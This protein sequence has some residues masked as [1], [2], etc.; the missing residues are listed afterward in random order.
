[1]DLRQMQYF[2]AIAEALSFS[3]AANTLFISQSYLSK[4]M[5]E[6][7]Q[8]LGVKLLTRTTRSVTLTEEGETLLWGVRDILKHRDS[9]IDSV[10]KAGTGAETYRLVVA[11]EAP[12]P[13][14]T[15]AF[16]TVT[17][18]CMKMAEAHPGLRIV[19][20]TIDPS[21]MKR[22]LKSGEIDV[23]I[24][25]DNEPPM[26]DVA[27][28]IK[29]CEEDI[30]LAFCST[31]PQEETAEN[32]RSV[33][34]KQTLFLPLKAINGLSNTLDV[35]KYL[36]VSPNVMFQEDLSSIKMTIASG[37]G[38]IITTNSIR[39]QFRHE[40]AHF[41]RLDMPYSKVATWLMWNS[42]NQNPSVRFFLDALKLTDAGLNDDAREIS[43]ESAS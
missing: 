11:H 18:A 1:M 35:L 32:I 10:R 27:E 19:F 9:V 7:E 2:L 16:T 34:E 39:N 17:K 29:L 33:L 4:Q 43:G 8:E 21:D 22:A 36:D 42:G 37:E 12:F 31:E 3:K 25:T 14:K 28:M 6:L 38:C 5:S 41:L 24:V 23:L 30:V 20:K 40:Y 15:E 26:S 13:D